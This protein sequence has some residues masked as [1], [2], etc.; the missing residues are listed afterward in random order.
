[1]SENIQQIGDGMLTR[2]MQYCDG[3][4]SARDAAIMAEEIAADPVLQA[5]ADDL[6]VGANAAREA[7]APVVNQPVPLAMVRN[8]VSSRSTQPAPSARG[9]FSQALAGKVAAALI[10][11][12]VGAASIGLWLSAD[13]PEGLRLAGSDT[14]GEDAVGSS[15]FRAALLSALSAQ[16]E[17]ATRPYALS[18]QASGQGQVSVLRWFQLASGTPCAEFAQEQSA[19][20]GSNGIACRRVDG[21]WELIT[22]PAT[23]R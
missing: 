3:T 12:A 16:P 15:A 13:Q 21:G 6:R 5:L 11:L 2:V 17:L 1:M 7:L 9:F 19:T 8:I 14:Q 20:I 4:L 18:D 22:L 23:A 10:G